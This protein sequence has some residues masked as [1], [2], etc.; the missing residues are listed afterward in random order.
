MT[1][2]LDYCNN[3]YCGLPLKTIKKLQLAQNAAARLIAK[4]LPQKS[5]SHYDSQFHCHW[6]PI[7]KRYQYKL[8]VLTYKTLHGTTPVYICDML[9]ETTK[10]WS[11]PVTNTQSSQ[12]YNV[13][14]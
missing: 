9:N 13:W 11:I 1:V 5:V 14:S 4:I 2:R 8:I 10:I 3:I 12:N 6:L 7:T